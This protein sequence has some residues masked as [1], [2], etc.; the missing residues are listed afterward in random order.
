M[1]TA[2]DAAAVAVGF[3][4]CFGRIYA[5]TM[6][7]NLNT[8]STLRRGQNSKTHTTG[9]GVTTTVANAAAIDLSQ[10]RRSQ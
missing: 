8:R 7:Y 1:T 9:G 10:I 5:L 3:N 2:T 6:L 4:E